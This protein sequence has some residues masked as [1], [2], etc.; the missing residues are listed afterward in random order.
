MK[1]FMLVFRRDASS[2]TIQMSP[3]QM[4]A[5]TKP[6][7]EWMDSLE[8]ANVLTSRGNRLAS[9]GRVVRPKGV[10]TTG[11]YVEIKEAIGGYIVVRAHDIDKAAELAKGCPILAMDG[12][13][14]VRSFVSMD[15]R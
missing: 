15:G 5:I 6:W 11:P 8:K 9:E 10:V 4:Q 14:E 3:D 12:T 13:V 2:A 7:Q 1:E